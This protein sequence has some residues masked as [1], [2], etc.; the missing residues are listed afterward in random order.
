[1]E[2]KKNPSKDVHRM[3]GMF[4]QIGLGISLAIVITAFE[5]RTEVKKVALRIKEDSG[6]ELIPEIPNTDVK[7]P[8]PPSPIKSEIT[9]VRGFVPTPIVITSDDDQS[10]STDNIPIV[11]TELPSVNYNVP[12]EDPE[13][14]ESCYFYIVEKNAEPAGGY[15]FFYKKLRENLKY[16]KK[17]KQYNVEGKV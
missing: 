10:P 17:A 11:D 1:M 14:C 13:D 7:E 4:F 2:A 9:P 6:F 5:W 16:P 12:P 15:E 8:P 3:S